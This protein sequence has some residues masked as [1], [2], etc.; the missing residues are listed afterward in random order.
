VPV[1]A[2][3]NHWTSRASAVTACAVASSAWEL[4]RLTLKAES[5]VAASRGGRADGCEFRRLAI[6]C[7]AGGTGAGRSAG[8]CRISRWRA[9]RSRLRSSGRGGQRG[10]GG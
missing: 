4:V 2:T 8:R 9:S 10:A 3:R 5:S 7:K 1:A 6:M